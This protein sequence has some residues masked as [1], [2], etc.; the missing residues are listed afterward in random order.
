MYLPANPV[1]FDRSVFRDLAALSGPVGGRQ[2]FSSYPVT[3]VDW[4]DPAVLEDIDTLDDYDQLI[5]Q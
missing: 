4:D 3:W 2:L 1:L 5:K